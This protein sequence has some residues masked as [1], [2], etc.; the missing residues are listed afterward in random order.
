MKPR[1]TLEA[2]AA[3]AAESNIEVLSTEYKNNSTKLQFRCNTCGNEWETKP[4]LIFRGQG[5]RICAK[6]RRKASMIAAHGVPFAGMLKGKSKKTVEV[7]VETADRLFGVPFVTDN[8]MKTAKLRDDF[9]VTVI[10]LANTPE[11]WKQIFK[12]R[13]AIEAE[14]KRILYFYSREWE[15]KR[16]IC[17]QIIQTNLGTHTKRI[18]ARKCTVEVRHCGDFFDRYHL[19]GNLRSAKYVCL[20]HEGEIVCAMS[21]RKKG[22]GVDISRFASV[23]NTIVQG[24]FTKLLKWVEDQYNPEFV[25]NWVDRRYGSGKHLL[26]KG[27]VLEHTNEGFWWT[28]KEGI[29]HNRL[30]CRAN[31]DERGMTEKQ[32]ADEL[33]WHRVYDAG[34]SKYIKY[35]REPLTDKK[36]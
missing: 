12:E 30:K 24:G 13:K 20:V 1:C 22:E 36:D 28:S 3:K 21:Y 16:H 18:P 5:C 25:L 15:N 9:I 31:M 23:E 34:Q 19:M 14:G 2:L 35:R 27:F 7:A 17:E 6:D 32:H 11:N 8:Y 26:E 4:A 29:L 33:G 10:D